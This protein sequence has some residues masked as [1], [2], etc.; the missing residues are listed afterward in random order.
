[1]VLIRRVNMKLPLSSNGYVSD[2]C[3]LMAIVI[4]LFAGSRR[5]QIFQKYERVIYKFGIQYF[6]SCLFKVASKL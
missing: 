5:D 6:L 4:I 2:C 3:L 1:M